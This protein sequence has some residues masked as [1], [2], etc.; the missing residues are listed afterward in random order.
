M[1]ARTEEEL[2]RFYDIRAREEL[3]QKERISAMRIQHLFKVRKAR[4]FVRLVA[5][6]VWI[7]TMDRD[8]GSYLYYNEVAEEFSPA[9]DGVEGALV[10]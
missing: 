4:K 2:N 10:R 3:R 5:Q 9:V 7:K 1:A 6:T 8:T